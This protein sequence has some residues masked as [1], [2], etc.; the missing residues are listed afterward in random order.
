ML[1]GCFIGPQPMW[2][3]NLHAKYGLFED[4][5][6]SAG[7]YEFWCRCVSNGEIF[8]HIDEYLGLY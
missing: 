4:E 2:R 6:V 8:Y 5:Y 3:S 1:R 7:D